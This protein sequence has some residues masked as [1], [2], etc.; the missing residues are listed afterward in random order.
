M[1]TRYLNNCGRPESNKL[2]WFVLKSM[3][4]GHAYIYRWLLDNVHLPESGIVLDVGCGGGAL[5]E[6]ILN[7]FPSIKT[8]GIDISDE[9]VRMCGELKK[10][11]PGRIEV[12]KADAVSLPFPDET[13]SLA[14]SCESIYFWKAPDK[15]LSE[16]YRTLISGSWL[17]VA[18]ETSDKNK[19]RIWS[20]RISGMTVYSPGELRSLFCNA[21][22]IHIESQMKGQACLVKGMKP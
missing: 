12:R 7:E 17:A 11:H 9:S 6:R 8:Y 21:G 15:A 16:I 20:D 1:F 10:K 14:L 4:K 13:F 18:V 5:M 22:F 19:A 3:N 2:G